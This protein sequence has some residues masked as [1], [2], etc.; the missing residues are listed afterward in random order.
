MVDT[1]MSKPFL[2]L[3]LDCPEDH[4]NFNEYAFQN[5]SVSD[6]YQA[7]IKNSGHSNFMDIPFMSNLSLI[8][9]TGKIDPEKAIEITSKIVIDFFYKYLNNEDTNLLEIANRYPE[10]EIEKREKKLIS[11]I[12]NK[13]NFKHIFNT[14]FWII[15]QQLPNSR[16]KNIKASA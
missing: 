2:L 11:H 7:K 13:P 14:N 16:N 10:L 3:S 4:P 12:Q 8:N 1:F 5:G 15:F 9:E 6:F